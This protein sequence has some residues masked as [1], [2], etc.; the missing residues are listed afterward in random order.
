MKSA[1]VVVLVCVVLTSAA[2]AQDDFEIPSGAI[3]AAADLVGF[4]PVL[5]ISPRQLGMGG[6]GIGVADDGAAWYQNPAAL[7]QL[8][9]C[10]AEGKKWANDVIG[11]I[12]DAT[13]SGFGVTWSGWQPEKRM[14]FGV[15]YLNSS[16]SFG[17]SA[18][19][20]AELFENIGGDA[21]DLGVDFG[22]G[23]SLEREIT[24]FG[25][26]FGMGLKNSP[27]SFGLSIIRNEDKFSAAM[28][29]EGGSLDDNN[30]LINLGFMYTFA[31]QD[32]APIRVGL[33][34]NDLTSERKAI[35]F[36][37]ANDN[38]AVELDEVS[39]EDIGPF[40]N[41]GV[42]WPVTPQWLVAID[43]T[44]ITDETDD[45]PFFSGGVEYSF[46]DSP[47]KLRAG[48]A[49]TGDGHDL[50]LG[51]GYAFGNQWR[52]DAAWRNADEDDIWSV[53]AGYT[54]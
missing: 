5:S 15:G 42:A 6:A 46:I 49:D 12:T 38:D 26:G 45:G 35:R 27:F 17:A 39:I 13:D 1:W 7:G 25:A 19:E 33:T 14:G 52:V 28:G 48:L 54:W 51:A 10:P 32:K 8:N 53:G 2:F 41:L 31:Q 40:F 43:V 50:T 36:N 4:R 21:D 30:T 20:I 37:D 11:S 24:Q 44:D 9:L 29:D 47:L 22:D 16:V 34:V 3:S 18:E 23:I